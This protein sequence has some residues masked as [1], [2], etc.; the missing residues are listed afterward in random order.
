MTCMK[1]LSLEE[2]ELWEV[3]NPLNG[4]PG[5]LLTYMEGSYSGSKELQFK[6]CTKTQS[7][8][9]CLT[10]SVFVEGGQYVDK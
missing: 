6:K 5:G 10:N 2:M 8:W 1:T 4:R 3:W 9:L 7:V